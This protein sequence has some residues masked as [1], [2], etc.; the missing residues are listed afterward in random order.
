MDVQPELPSRYKQLDLFGTENDTGSVPKSVPASTDNDTAPVPKSVH[1][2][3]PN[4]TK[5]KTVCNTHVVLLKGDEV[6]KEKNARRRV[7]KS[8]HVSSKVL[9]E[10]EGRN[11]GN[12]ERS[13]NMPSLNQVEEFFHLQSYPPDEAKKFFLYNQGKNWMLTDKLKIKDWQAL[14]HKWML[15]I[16]KKPKQENI[17]EQTSNDI[18]REV[19]F[20]YESFLGGKKIFQHITT[21]HF[22]QLN[23]LL[24][25]QTIEQAKQQRIKDIEGTNQYSIGQIWQAYLT[26]NP[27]NPIVQKDLPNVMELAKRIAVIKHFQSQKNQTNEH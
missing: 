3:K 20:L 1:I 7:P 10:V 17:P 4:S 15:N 12:I 2:I 27:N 25:D 21:Q 6:A 14:A 18:E 24:D 9:S 8:V 5:Q 23:L 19:Q 16:K 22:E 26:N 11:D 13:R